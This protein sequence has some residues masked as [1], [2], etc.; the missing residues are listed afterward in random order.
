MEHE[1]KA[2]AADELG[3]QDGQLSGLASVHVR[4]VITWLAIFPLAAIGMT[5]IAAVAPSWPSVLR[6]LALTLVVVPI[7]VYFV[8]PALLLL[9]V[10]LRMS[11]ARVQELRRDSRIQTVGKPRRGGHLSRQSK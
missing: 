7:S 1:G 10:R 8:V 5:T 6:A 4:V 2:L 3:A 9:H 11:V